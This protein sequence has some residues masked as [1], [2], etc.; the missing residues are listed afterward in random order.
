[1]GSSLRD[2]AAVHHQNFIAEAAASQPVGDQQG[3]FLLDELLEILKDLRLGLG[4]IG[5]S[6]FVQDNEPMCQ[7]YAFGMKSLV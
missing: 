1:M 3:S 6:R 5:G 2:P 7:I 4:V